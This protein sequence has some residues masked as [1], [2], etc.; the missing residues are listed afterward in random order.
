MGCL[1]ETVPTG[2]QRQLTKDIYLDTNL[3]N[4]LC[5]QSVE[6]I[7]LVRRLASKNAYLAPGIHT[8]YELAK[9]FRGLDEKSRERGKALFSHFKEFLLADTRCLKNN[10]ELLAREMWAGS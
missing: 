10:M 5:D 4:V 1:G 7:A 8:F 6:P 9:N 3:W 2:A